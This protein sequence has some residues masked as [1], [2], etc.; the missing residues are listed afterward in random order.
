MLNFVHLWQNATENG[1]Q[2]NATQHFSYFNE[3]D[4]LFDSGSARS[5]ESRI[6]GQVPSTEQTQIAT[7]T[8]KIKQDELLKLQRFT[9]NQKPIV[10]HIGDQIKLTCLPPFSNPKPTIFWYKDQTLLKV[11]RNDVW[12]NLPFA[13]IKKRT[14]VFCCFQNLSQKFSFKQPQLQLNWNKLGHFLFCFTITNKIIFNLKKH[15]KVFV[16]SFEKQYKNSWIP[17]EI[18]RN[19][20]EKESSFETIKSADENKSGFKLKIKPNKKKK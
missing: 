19:K 7:S 3:T 5:N 10:A 12:F 16:Q 8:P 17:S 6:S 9:D 4:D 18:D 13:K 2:I 11:S 1:L 15:C 14:I 20:M